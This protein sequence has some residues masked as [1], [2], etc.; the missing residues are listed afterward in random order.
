M[1]GEEENGAGTWATVLFETPF[2]PEE[3]V[4]QMILENGQK[5]PLRIRMHI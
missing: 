1:H 2:F 3:E 5:L 4:S